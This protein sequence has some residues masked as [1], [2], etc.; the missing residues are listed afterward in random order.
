MYSRRCRG[1][2]GGASPYLGSTPPFLP[3][4]WILF[5]PPLNWGGT[6]PIFPN[7]F[8]V[9]GPPKLWGPPIISILV[10]YMG[11]GPPKSGETPPNEQFDFHLG[12]PPKFGG[13]PL[14]YHRSVLTW[15]STPFI[16]Y[17]IKY[18]FYT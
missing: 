16:F 9:L 8:F 12:G 18:P 3:S 10:V 14:F 7:F 2:F 4:L 1:S 5:G 17:V 6:P 11:G 13:P 15:G